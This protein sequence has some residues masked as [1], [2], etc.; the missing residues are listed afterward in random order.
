MQ[1]KKKLIFV[2]IIA[3]LL[4]ACQ[5][6]PEEESSSSSLPPPDSSSESSEESSFIDPLPVDGLRGF[7]A[8]LDPQIDDYPLYL[9]L[10]DD[11]STLLIEGLELTPEWECE[12]ASS[13]YAVLHDK[14]DGSVKCELSF[15]FPYGDL[16]S[17]TIIGLKDYP[18]LVFYQGYTVYLNNDNWDEFFTYT[19]QIEEIYGSQGNLL[20]INVSTFYQLEPVFQQNLMVVHATYQVYYLDV[21]VDMKYAVASRLSSF[22]LVNEEEGSEDEESADDEDP[23]YYNGVSLINSKNMVLTEDHWGQTIWI[24]SD[25]LTD[26]VLEE[27]L[28]MRLPA[29]LV[30]VQG[31]LVLTCPFSD[32]IG[33]G[34]KL[35]PFPA[36]PDAI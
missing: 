18:P 9:I 26:G 15:L 6:I 2:L 31:Y 7:W 33:Q 27:I 12:E 1:I 13:G 23:S 4:T 25:N 36:M 14:E 32:V 17:V 16:P 28:T 11:V 21:Q 29:E 20:G 35:V 30:R 10:S 5:K 34:H 19:Y 22:L 8:R 24:N 3:L